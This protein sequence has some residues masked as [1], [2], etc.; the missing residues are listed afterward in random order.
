MI[1]LSKIKIQEKME[2][3]GILMQ[4]EAAIKVDWLRFV[5]VLEWIF[6]FF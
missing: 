5:E 4:L 1:H 6:F 3:N 2:Q